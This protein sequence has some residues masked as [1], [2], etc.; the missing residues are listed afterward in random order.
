[1]S[2]AVQIEPISSPEW[3]R[4]AARVACCLGVD[5]PVASCELLRAVCAE[6]KC[7]PFV[8]KNALAAAEGL[9]LVKFTGNGW[10]AA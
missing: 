9:G 1:M 10:L 5:E 6:L 4:R 3:P 8:A 2:A 7:R